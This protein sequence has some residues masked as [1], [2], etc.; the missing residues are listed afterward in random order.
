MIT[1]TIEKK[2]VKWFP[3]SKKNISH[4]KYMREEGESERGDC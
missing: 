1:F 3:Y 2:Y 4:M